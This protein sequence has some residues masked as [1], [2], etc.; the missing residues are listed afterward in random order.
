MTKVGL[1][2]L[3]MQTAD[4]KWQNV[5]DVGEVEIEDNTPQTEAVDL[6]KSA[7][8]SGTIE[9]TK[10]NRDVMSMIAFGCT[11]NQYVARRLIAEDLHLAFRYS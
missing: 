1:K 10:E 3:Q 5:A 9:I 8:A 11:Y 7:T 4:G 6:S 2:N